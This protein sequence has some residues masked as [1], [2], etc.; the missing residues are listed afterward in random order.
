M[1]SD[2]P[3]LRHRSP[4]GRPQ[5]RTAPPNRDG[6]RPGPTQSLQP[7]GARAA[8]HP[9][10]TTTGRFVVRAQPAACACCC[11]V[12]CVRV[13]TE[14]D[15]V[16]AGPPPVRPRAVTV[17]MSVLPPALVLVL[18]LVASV[19]RVGRRSVVRCA[20][21]RRGVAWGPQDATRRG[22]H[23]GERLV[24]CPVRTVPG[25]DEIPRLDGQPTV[26]VP[27]SE[28]G[29]YVSRPVQLHGVASHSQLKCQMY[30]ALVDTS[31][32]AANGLSLEV[33]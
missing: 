30:L 17:H 11:G 31:K 7:Y 21:V 32:G 1:T 9:S 28:Y 18:A 27:R 25:G 14:L 16:E 19:R 23:A 24:Q 3:S 29:G 2:G 12:Q 10:P 8:S 6:P 22:D 13:T 5:P 15:G 4:D 26:G 20:I 33:N